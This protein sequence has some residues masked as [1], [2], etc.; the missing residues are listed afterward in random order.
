M[1]KVAYI[2][3]IESAD[4][5]L[6]YIGSTCNFEKR[7]NKHKYNY[8]SYLKT[9][10]GYC[11]SYEIIKDDGYICSILETLYNISKNDLRIRE[12]DAIKNCIN[13]VNK[14][15]AGR[16][17]KESSKVHYQKYSAK[18]KQKSR[19][20]RQQNAAKINQQLNCSCGGKYTYKHKAQHN[21]TKK[22]KDYVEKQE[23][24]RK[25]KEA[26]MKVLEALAKQQALINV[27]NNSGTINLN[28]TIN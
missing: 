24:K 5:C 20:Y 8:K 9:G 28:I 11:S 18:I 6:F 3:S 22:H 21:S 16:T 7:M 10:K 14:L 4:G 26:I 27:Q 12:G 23:Q 25:L 2:Y 17:D 13:C 19:D 15:V 1:Y